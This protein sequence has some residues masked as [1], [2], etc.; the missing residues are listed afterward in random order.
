MDRGGAVGQEP[1][2]APFLNGLFSRGFSR[3][4]RATKEFGETA[5]TG[6]RG[7]GQLR[8]GNGPLLI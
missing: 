3:G 2:S 6:I 5:H 4:K 1:L 7:N 8:S